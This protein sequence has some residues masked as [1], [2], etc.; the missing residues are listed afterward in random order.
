M[1]AIVSPDLNIYWLYLTLD[2]GHNGIFQNMPFYSDLMSPH[3]NN[4]WCPHLNS[5]GSPHLND[6]LSPHLNDLMSSELN[7]LGCPHSQGL[8][9]GVLT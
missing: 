2:E 8:V 1:Y 4:L 3:L 9:L 5:L 7:D 6:L